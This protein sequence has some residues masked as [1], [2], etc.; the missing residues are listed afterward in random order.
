MKQI[1]R[2]LRSEETCQLQTNLENLWTSTNLSPTNLFK[3]ESFILLLSSLQKSYDH[4]WNAWHFFL[5]WKDKIKIL[6]AFFKFTSIETLELTTKHLLSNL[7]CSCCWQFL[8]YY[9]DWQWLKTYWILIDLPF[10]KVFI[11]WLNSHL[12]KNLSLKFR[13]S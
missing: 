7:D 5:L 6:D 2:E 1:I 11:L 4:K 3:A 9:K 12:L 10:F 8:S 13:T